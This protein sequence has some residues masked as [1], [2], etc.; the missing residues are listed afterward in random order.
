MALKTK[1]FFCIGIL[2]CVLL[3]LGGC[4]QKRSEKLD[5]HNLSGKTI[6]CMLGYSSDYILTNEYQDVNLR[7]FDAYSDMTLALAFH[8]LDAAAME[9]DEAYVFCRLNP[10]YMIYGIFAENDRYA[11]ILNP[12]NPELNN[13]FNSF[14]KQFRKTDTYKDMEQR[15]KDC[16][17]KPFKSKHVENKY[18][19]NRILKVMVYDGW[20]PVSYKNTKT[21]EWEGTEIEL[22]TYFANSIGAK[23]KFYPAG[24][25]T[26]A[27]LD[28]SVGK[29][30]IFACPDSTRLG[31]DLEKGGHVIQSDWIWEKD[32]VIIVNTADYQN[33]NKRT[34]EI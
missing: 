25:Y 1:K 5:I 3:S 23:V 4:A 22:V 29:T 18:K 26:Q 34:G 13:Q 10:K 12:H 20:E 14:V 30:D 31:N 9:M 2:L 15:V 7:R 19:G 17:K 8:Q 11:Y 28:M 32:I 16:S 21:N 33:I 27:V 6:G 24:S